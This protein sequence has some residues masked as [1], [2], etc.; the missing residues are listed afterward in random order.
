MA[1]VYYTLYDKMLDYQ[2]LK[3][4]FQK[5]K[6]AD[7]APGIDGQTTA[8]FEQDLHGNLT[9]LLK[10]L[11][12][13]SYRP[14]PVREVL[15]PKPDG[16]TRK[17]GLPTVRDKVVQQALKSILQPICEPEFHPSSYAYRPN[18][19]QHQAI[20]KAALFIRRYRM[21]QVVDIDIAKCFDKLDHSLIMRAFRRL[22][23]DGSILNLIRMFL[24]SGVMNCEGWRAT[25]EGSPQGGV[26]SPLIAN[27]YLNSFD[28]FAKERGHRIVRFA[29]DIRIFKYSRRGAE[30]SLE[31]AKQYLEKELRLSLNERKTRIV[32]ADE[33]VDF[34]GVKIYPLYT[35]IQ[36][37][38][39]ARLKQKVKAKTKRNNT[40]KN[41][42]QTIDE[43]N[44]VI[45]GF[46]NYYRIANCKG[47]IAKIAKWIRRRLRAKQ[48]KLW[49]TRKKLRR[50]LRQLGYD[51]PVT[52]CRMSYWA[53]SLSKLA[54]IAI[55]NSY[56][57]QE[58]GL[59]DIASVPVGIPVLLPEGISVDMSRIRG[60]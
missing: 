30:N 34:L 12:E 54:H 3:Q 18:R 52:C 46:I 60:P 41:L 26:I 19:S 44:P 22:I 16:G 7:G 17:L 33:G 49:K 38:R 43:L 57:H 42:K 37:N 59:F 39:V 21:L 35:S 36:E 2:R 27:L 13:K 5:V 40:S 15:I 32:H 25:S 20:A 29:D 14:L 24:E 11:R 50:R 45:R 47:K 51:A 1:R 48:L 28:Q 6:A 53:S 9:T 8:D 10:Q 23:A 55:P 4:G 31:Q 58:M 56:L